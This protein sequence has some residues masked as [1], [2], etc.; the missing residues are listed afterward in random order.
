MSYQYKLQK[1]GGQRKLLACDGGGIRGIIAI[2][3]LAR[4]E[5]ENCARASGIRSWF[6]RITLIM[7]PARAPGP[8]SPRLWRSPTALTTSG[9][10]T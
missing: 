5:A 3:T 8:S 2:E 7:L 6:L 1:T 9:T 4:V 10:F